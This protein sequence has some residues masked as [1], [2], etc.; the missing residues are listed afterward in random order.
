MA[1]SEEI[2]NFL[3]KAS[4]AI[5]PLSG[6]LSVL[7]GLGGYLSSKSKKR[8]ELTE[9]FKPPKVSL[10]TIEPR[11]LK[12]APKLKRGQ[13]PKLKRGFGSLGDAGLIDIPRVEP[14]E[15]AYKRPRYGFDGTDNPAEAQPEFGDPFDFVESK[16]NQNPINRK[17]RKDILKSARRMIEPMIAR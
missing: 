14:I 8:K 3:F 13:L 5:P 7:E 16:I 11:Q 1:D 2:G 9:S 4:K 15:K 12:K 10:P 6:S 17:N